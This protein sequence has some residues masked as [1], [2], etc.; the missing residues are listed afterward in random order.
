MSDSSMI[1]KA[2]ELAVAGQLVRAGIHI[3]MPLVDNGIDL[4]AA[5]R[6]GKVF[7]P[8]Q[9][10]YKQSRSGF[11]LHSAKAETYDKDA[12]LAFGSAADEDEGEEPFYF[13][14]VREWLDAA[15]EQATG[16]LDEKISI[17]IARTD[18]QWLNQRKGE[19]GMR[20]AF[21]GIFEANARMNMPARSA[22]G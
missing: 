18:P 14:K 7:V 6:D 3:F 19:R 8:V 20:L 10:K 21:A 2:K 4:I 9:V 17:Y 1:G 5:S 15:R 22:I 16:R 12:V 11:T 13:F